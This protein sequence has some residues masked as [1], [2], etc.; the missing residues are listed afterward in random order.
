M[1]RMH[2]DV[3]FGSCVVYLYEIARSLLAED[4][5]CLS[6]KA[7]ERHACMDRLVYMDM[8]SIPYMELLEHSVNRRLSLRPLVFLEFLPCPAQFTPVLV[9]YHVI[10]YVSAMKEYIYICYYS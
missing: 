4:G 8:D 6:D 9:M 3:F 5:A 1:N 10:S 7:S 2:Q